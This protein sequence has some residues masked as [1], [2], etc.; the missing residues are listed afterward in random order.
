MIASLLQGHSCNPATLSLIFPENAPCSPFP[1]YL[2]QRSQQRVRANV[3]WP[4]KLEQPLICEAIS[5]TA[6]W[7][8]KSLSS[9][10]ASNQHL[11]VTVSQILFQQEVNAL[12][13]KPQGRLI[14]VIIVFI[15][16]ESEALVRYKH[17]KSILA[18]LESC[19]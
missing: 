15:S 4:P 19:I 8:P 16:V 2:L 12:K 1:S 7:W 11:D 5:S 3:Q 14:V 13:L 17:N 18:N 9:S 6:G 10:E